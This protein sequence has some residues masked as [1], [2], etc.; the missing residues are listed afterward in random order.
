[1]PTAAKVVAAV[2]MAAVAW[3]VSGMVKGLL[4]E[5]TQT[6]LLSEINAVLGFIMGWTI[7]GSRAGDGYKAAVGY[8]WTA[9][10]ATIFWALVVW[11]GYEMTVNATRLRYDGPLEAIN[12]F[13]QI[14]VEYLAMMGTGEVIGTL[15][16][17]GAVAGM[18]AE[19]AGRRWR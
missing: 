14:C 9:V 5:G 13:F 7:I 8:G 2:F 3:F 18:M 17:G 16:L 4:P 1:M 19:W 12:D 11:G 10:V 15:L 6:G